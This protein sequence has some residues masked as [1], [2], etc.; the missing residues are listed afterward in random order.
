M[1][2]NLI[3]TILTKEFIQLDIHVSVHH[4]IKNE[5]DQQDATV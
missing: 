2:Y 4:D 3:P 1:H 5:N